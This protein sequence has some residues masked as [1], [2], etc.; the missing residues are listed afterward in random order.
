LILLYSWLSGE[1]RDWKPSLELST[2]TREG[3]IL[4]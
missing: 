4:V 3:L 2:S 1:V